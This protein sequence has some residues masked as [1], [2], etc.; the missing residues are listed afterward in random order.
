M[1]TLSL[2]R[3]AKAAVG[4]AG[5]KDFDRPLAERGVATATLMGAYLAREGLQP[6]FVLASPSARTRSTCG[7]VFAAMPNPPE[8]RYEDVL[9]LASPRTLLGRIRRTPPEVRHL[10]LI[11][12]NPGLQTLA[13]ELVAT[14]SGKPPGKPLADLGAKLPTAGL[15]VLTFDHPAWTATGAQTAALARFVTPRGLAV[16]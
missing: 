13:L 15:V 3:H 7:L 16:Q 5:M 8:I 10:M 4:D 12:H 6:D 9:Y 11:G 2:L 1:L 14:G